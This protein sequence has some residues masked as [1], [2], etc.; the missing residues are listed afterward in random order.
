MNVLED[1]NCFFRSISHQL[2]G[3]ESEHMNIPSNAIFYMKS[4]R[5][6]FTNFI[7]HRYLSIENYFNTMN[8]GGTYTNNLLILATTTIINKN[9]IIHESCKKTYFNSRI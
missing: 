6:D 4:N 7:D 1:G 2:Y 5:N 8:E 3:N 9:I